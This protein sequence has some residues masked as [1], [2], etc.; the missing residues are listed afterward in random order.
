VIRLISIC[1]RL[2]CCLSFTGLFL[3]CSNSSGPEGKTL[4][5][6]LSSSETQIEFANQLAE[7][8]SFNIIEYLYFYNGGGV[9]V[10]DVDNDGLSDIYFTSNQGPNK[11]YRNQ[12]NFR[13]IDITEKSGA[14]GVGNWKTGV[15]MADVN[16]DGF[17]DIFVCGVGAYK[18]FDG[19]NQLFINHGDLTFSDQTKQYGLSFQGFST[20]ASFFDYDN[21]GDLD[22]YLLNHS[23]HSVRSY[24]D[25][26]Y[27]LQSDYK[28][29]DKLYRNEAI[30]SGRME[31]TEVTT[32]AGIFSSQIGYGLGLAVSDLN[33]DGYLDIYVSN[34][35]HENDYLYV[36]QRDGTFKQVIEMS[37][38]HTSR[39]SM[40][41]D[42]GDINNDGWQDIIT[43]DMLPASEPVIK[44]SGG[45]DPYEIFK[46]K[47][48]FG[49]HYQFA[50][51][52]LQLNRGVDPEGRL[53][54]SDIAPFSG[55]AATD[56]SWA[57]LLADF[58]ND[59]NRDLFVAN[60][61][62][63][64]PNDLDYITY[65]SGDSAQRFL[66]DQQMIDHMPSGKV[67]NYFFKNGGQLSFS[68]V[69]TE[70]IDEEPALSNGAAY[71]DLDNDGDLDLVVNNLNEKASIYRNEMPLDSSYFLRVKLEGSAF[72][73][74]G[75]GGKVFVHIGDRVLYNELMPSR[76]WQSSSE[77]V[78]HFGLGMVPVPDSVTVVW[79]NQT[80]QIVKGVKSNET[81]TLRQNDGEGE[82]KYQ[83]GKK[84]TLKAIQAV[85]FAHR[86]NEYSS[87]ERERL[88]PHMLSTQGPKFSV[89]DINGDRLED[90]FVGGAR[91]QASQVFLQDRSGAFERT[92][93][94]A[95]LADSLAEDI[96]SALADFNG[97][98]FLD[99]VVAGG[100]QEEE[101]KY[102]NLRPRLYVNDGKG[103]FSKVKNAIPGIYLNGSC[104][105]A[106]D[107]EVDGDMDL[108]IGARVVVDKYGETPTSYLLRNDGQGNFSIDSLQRV[109]SDVGLVTDAVWHDFNKDGMPDLMLT[110]EWMPIT[111]LIQ[112]SQGIL[113]NKTRE[114][115]L[116]NTSG[117]WNGLSTGDLDHDGDLDF[118]AGNLGLNSRLKATMEEPLELWI[119]DVDSNGSSD[120]IITYYN[121]HLR[122]PF[123]SRDQL[124]KQIP[125]MKR[126]FLKYD[127][128]KNAGL[129]DVISKE[130]QGQFTHKKAEMLTSIWLE[131]ANGKLVVHPLPTE[132][133]L[134]PIFAFEL[135]DVN[136]DGHLDVL[137]VGNWY[138]VQPDYGRYDAGY[139][140]LLLGN[141]T[142][143][144][145]SQT[146][147]SSG[148]LVEGEGRCVEAVVNS[149]G[150]RL[151]LV[152]RNNDTL[153]TFKVQ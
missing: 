124:I 34:D 45:E 67:A 20:H 73:R 122:Y 36:N 54:F 33:N 76:G 63:R 136:Q 61:I 2:F 11:L 144:F 104:V 147:Q 43:L 112:N 40:G 97:D 110:G 137:A 12:G 22:L 60:G 42:V 79:P 114:F 134:F 126:K 135:I 106:V 47:L 46:F 50:R 25:A 78:L 58:D 5:T 151:I 130:R 8:D 83:P 37:I 108:F 88:T 7:T 24:G 115:G 26:S 52:T 99:L 142:G 102:D 116:E 64:R 70:W 150:E 77:G 85:D 31:F 18:G 138:A 153:L 91:G 94:P 113:E 39:F 132:A 84:T 56:W 120:P 28:A 3:S 128:Y 66:S 23:V 152:G 143:N 41:N 21:D 87:F 75:V 30:P 55:L 51:N 74:N 14:A 44:A 145:H 95:L 139:G 71:G 72:N 100:G 117:W 107:F 141:G 29:G 103:K 16:G 15:T 123:A 129:D 127:D 118:V 101:G 69:S 57:P 49:Y 6:K 119:G 92:Y 90:L 4:F 82:W 93:Q 27:R 9:A 35:F 125:S 149:K 48:G 89:G 86:E 140:L 96:G 111:V 38:P 146:L 81:I 131:N 62:L 68:D 10:G 32:Q 98:G 80:F 19:R 1:I 13:F 148:F 133:Q 109:L 53:L 17:L 65:I 105:K 121:Q 59:G